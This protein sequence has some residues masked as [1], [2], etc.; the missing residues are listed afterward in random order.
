MMTTDPFPLT[1]YAG[2]NALEIIKR[3]G[4]GPGQVKVI[5]GAAGGPKWLVL[6]E[7]DR[8]LF[9]QWLL[10]AAEPL[11]LIGSSIAAWRFACATQK[12][13]VGALD[14]FQ[15]AY[16]Q[17]TYSAKPSAAEVTAGSQKILDC[18][19]DETTVEE[20]LS[21]PSWRLNLLAVRC[22]PVV[23]SENGI[24]L[25]SGLVVS[26]ISNLLS[27]KS[28]SL[29]YEQTLFYNQTQVPVVETNGFQPRAVPLT[30]AN[31]KPAILASGSIP[32]VMSGVRDIPGAP[33]GVYRDGGIVDYHLDI[34]FAVDD[35][36]V[37]FPHYTGRVIPGWF[38]K[39]LPWRKPVPG[40]MQNV[41]LVAPSP[42][43]VATLPFGKIPDRG[44]FKRFAGR[45]A[46]RMSYWRTVI[47]ESER[48]ADAFLEIGEK[49]LRPELVR[50]L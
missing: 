7:L 47:G 33:P 38:D 46:E 36:I 8:V 3:D 37:L 22:K 9:S 43:F 34:P 13:P 44:D 18:F 48:M 28:L 17:Q 6:G 20:V 41:L 30:A 31:L 23:A 45:D 40:N 21:H 39:S 1:F 42:A 11:V 19:L 2:S 25:S 32:L 14:K 10:P 12:D 50:P 15:D 4:F 35:G 16:I 24:A 27:R 29:F 49:G 5:A 26:A